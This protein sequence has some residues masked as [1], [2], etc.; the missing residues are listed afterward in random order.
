MMWNQCC[1]RHVWPCNYNISCAGVI[2]V[3]HLGC[4]LQFYW[5]K[6]QPETGCET[7]H[8]GRWLFW[9]SVLQCKE[10]GSIYLSDCLRDKIV[11]NWKP[12]EVCNIGNNS[13]RGRYQYLVTKKLLAGMGCISDFCNIY[14]PLV[15]YRVQ[16]CAFSTSKYS[17]HLLCI[18]ICTEYP[19]SVIY[20]RFT[21]THK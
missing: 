19:T 17:I 11:I 2:R 4:T 1:L 15:P 5:L 16:I 9:N 3:L 8:Q 21:H 14:L 10:N 12:L 6:S 7:G 18:F 20:H 13:Q